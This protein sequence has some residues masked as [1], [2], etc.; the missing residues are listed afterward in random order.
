MSSPLVSIIVPVF[1]AADYLKDCLSSIVSQD[2]DNIEVVVV[3][4]E[5]TDD[6]FKIVE[7]MA[8]NNTSIKPYK[9]I[10]SGVSAARN[11]GIKKSN[12][13]YI[14]FVDSD[15]TVEPDYVS[16][17]IYKMNDKTMNI[18]GYTE[19]IG[20]KKEEQIFHGQIQP[21]NFR[22]LMYAD[23]TIGGFCCNKIY[24]RKVIMDNSI[25]FD[26]EVRNLED[27]LFNRT[28]I[29]Y[30]NQINYIAKTPYNYYRRADSASTVDSNQL[31]DRIMTAVRKM[32]E[33][34]AQK[35]LSYKKKYNELDYITVETS[36]RCGRTIDK[37][38]LRHYYTD[39]MIPAKR[40]TKTLLKITLHPL[41]VGRLGRKK[42][43]MGEGNHTENK[44]KVTIITLNGYF[45]YGNRLQLFALASYLNERLNAVVYVYKHNAFKTRIKELVKYDT[46]LRFIF[47]KESKLRAFTKK[48]LQTQAN[49]TECDC[50][51]VGSDQVWNPKLLSTRQYL[52]DAPTNSKKISYAASL[53][54]DELT[55]NQVEM[56]RRALIQYDAISVREQSAKRLL[57]PLTTKDI[58]VVLDPTLL[59]DCKRYEQL[60][61][62]PKG[63]EE[64]KGYVLC[65]ILGNHDYQ[66]LISEY[67]REHHYDVILFSDQRDSDYGV[68]EF[69]YLIHHARLVCTDSFHACVFS[70][71]FERPFVV[72]K[73][74]GKES[75][76][77][78][79]I[80]DF[81]KLFQLDSH[82]FN[83]KSISNSISTADYR[84]AKRILVREQKQSSEY[85]RKALGGNDEGE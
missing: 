56:F 33:D 45:N 41:Y 75:R 51:I 35:Q 14:M 23:N 43:R 3:D 72:F 83:G 46:P 7:K 49:Y 65:Y 61:K 20:N 1:N 26:K 70:F 36:A 18:C 19:I 2:Y 31:F 42:K 12:G 73:R 11:H 62:K 22:F 53:G 27:M 5:S 6:S 82:E 59:L 84:N 63:L 48:H 29:S 40:R 8:V 81:I 68:E 76:M 77:Y 78:S 66:D 58:E 32:K 21:E 55:D 60:E 74:S 39:S 25:R 80:R 50:C 67:A 28:Y 52:L 34:D 30:I 54:V 13:D 15:D 16:S 57:Q 37:D 71:I 9:I 38:L 24:S 79:R 85:L 44:K 69:L 10:H 4:D 17:M 64:D 47:K